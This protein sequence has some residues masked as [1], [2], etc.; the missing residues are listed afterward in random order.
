MP[1]EKGKGKSKV[2]PSGAPLPYFTTAEKKAIDSLSAPERDRL[3]LD[4]LYES[5]CTVNE[6]VNVKVSDLDPKEATAH[7]RSEGNKYR[8]ERHCYISKSLA[9]RIERFCKDK[10]PTSYIFDTR[11]SAQM[12]TKRIRQLVM[13]YLSKI[14]LEYKAFP[15]TFRYTHII[16]AYQKGVPI[17]AIEAQVGLKHTR[18]IQVIS[19]LETQEEKKIY[20]RF[21]GDT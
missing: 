5:G 9:K 13:I 1:R 4:F 14:H 8:E 20:R 3:I 17:S 6:L 10:K 12:T 19:S 2:K 7:I 21:L 18:L 15:Q 11:Q 16:H